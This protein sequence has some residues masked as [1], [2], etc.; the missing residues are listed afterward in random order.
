MFHVIDRT[1]GTSEVKNVIYFSAIEGKVDIELTELEAGVFAQVIEIGGASGEQVV[2]DNDRVTIS[3]E[4]ITEMRSEEA[5]SSS[6]Q[7]AR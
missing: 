4:C 6:D 1:G 7:G 3:K 2:D 5:S